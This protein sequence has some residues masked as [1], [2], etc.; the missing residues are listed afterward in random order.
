MLVWGAGQREV[1]SLCLAAHQIR[2]TVWLLVAFCSQRNFRQWLREIACHWAKRMQVC[3]LELRD[4]WAHKRKAQSFHCQW[5]KVGRSMLW[6][7]KCP[8]D[9]C[10]CTDTN[11]DNNSKITPFPTVT[12]TM[13]YGPDPLWHLPEMAGC[14]F[15][16]SSP[17][18]LPLGFILTKVI[19]DLRRLEE[20]HLGG[21]VSWASDSWFWLR[22]QSQGH[23]IELLVRIR[24]H[25]M[26]ACPSPSAPLPPLS[27]I[28][29]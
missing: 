1:A 25:T 13:R 5:H 3:I 20:G 24:A 2:H 21:S 15:L 27:H 16:L 28:Y 26:S 4:S 11:G 12:E 17:S 18:G 19:I 7:M 14:P 9:D 10:N 23:E 22:S 29:T 8:T 6:S